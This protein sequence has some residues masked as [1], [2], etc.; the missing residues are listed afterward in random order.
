M[1]YP[2]LILWLFILPLYG[3]PITVV[4]EDFPP[5]QVIE[6][7]HVSGLRTDMV[8]AILDEAKVEYSIQALPWARAYNMALTQKN[9]LIYSMIRSEER[10]NQFHWVGLL[11]KVQ[12]GLYKLKSRTD[13]N[14]TRLQ[15]AK[16][17]VTAVANKDFTHQ[18]L[19]G[20]GFFENTHL[21]VL[22]RMDQARKMLYLNRVDL[23]LDAPIVLHYA[24]R[25]FNLDPTR[26]E[27]ALLLPELE[28][29]HYMAFSLKTPDALVFKV[30]EAYK[31]V[32]DSGLFKT[33]NDEWHKN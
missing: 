32:R 33:L 20:N 16:K 23:I 12:G 9:T 1:K 10:E 8:R 3:A 30:K 13:I 24:A 21:H 14:I 18:Y 26:Y 7:N 2:A 25:R 28:A 17:Y 27:M 15:Q 5:F 29:Q 31:K 4:T 11:G 6:G 22:P 19:L